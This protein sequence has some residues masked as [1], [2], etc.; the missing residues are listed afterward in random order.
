MTERRLLR[1]WKLPL[2]L[3]S[4]AILTGGFLIF[5]RPL[6]EIMQVALAMREGTLAYLV[7]ILAGIPFTMLYDWDFVWNVAVASGI[8]GYTFRQGKTLRMNRA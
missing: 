4:A 2:V 8:S 3:F 5:S 7:I 6:L 1:R